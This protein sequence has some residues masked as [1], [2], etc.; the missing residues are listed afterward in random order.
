MGGININN[1]SS[2]EKVWVTYIASIYVENK[3]Y[4]SSE[5]SSEIKE[6]SKK[7]LEKSIKGTY[8]KILLNLKYV[9]YVTDFICCKTL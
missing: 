5:I 8:I 2:H 3:I 1:S 7:A 9:T 4:K 6:L